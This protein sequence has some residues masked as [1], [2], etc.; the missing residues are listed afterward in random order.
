MVYKRLKKHIQAQINIK[1][2]LL[3]TPNIMAPNT[4]PPVCLHIFSHN[5]HRLFVVVRAA[6]VCVRACVIVQLKR[7]KPKCKTEIEQI[8]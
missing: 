8:P 6:R 4:V 2:P 3:A 5:H 7:Y 1:R